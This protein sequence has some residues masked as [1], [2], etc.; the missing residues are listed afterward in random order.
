MTVFISRYLPLLSISALP[1]G[2][3]IWIS[4]ICADDWNHHPSY[5]YGWFILPL[6]F[7]FLYR[8][9]NFFETDALAP[10]S[11]SV[12]WLLPVPVV[13]LVL[14]LIRL[15][16]IFWRTIPWCIFT[17]G[18]TVTILILFRHG[19]RH[20]VNQLLF[21]VLFFGL[22]IP[23][24]TVI[25]VTVI[26]E[27]SFWVAQ[28]VGEFLM[29]SGVYCEVQGKIIT[30]TNGSVGVDEAC[31]GLRSLQAS[32]MVG[33]AVGEWRLMAWS[34]RFLL[35]ALAIGIA[36]LSN[37][38]RTY[39]LSLLIV[40]GGETL[41]NEWHDTI[42]TL[43]MI[44][45]TLA[46]V[47]VAFFFPEQTEPD[48]GFRWSALIQK[49]PVW[50]RGLA[51]TATSFF[52]FILAH[53]WFSIH[54]I[55][56]SPDE[57]FLNDS[58]WSESVIQQAPP[59]NILNILRADSGGYKLTQ[60]RTAGDLIA[61]HFFWKPSRSNGKVLFHR[62][63]VC[64]PG[65]GWTQEG[66]AKLIHG[67]LN[68]RKT[69]IHH[70]RFSRSSYQ[71]NLY[72]ICWTDD[73]PVAFEA[74]ENSYLQASFLTEFIQLGKRIFSVE[75]FGLATSTEPQSNQEWNALLSHLGALHFELTQ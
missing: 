14:E 72:W 16:P 9:L 74:S 67:T 33:F 29:L 64:M 41:F 39:V 36:F 19:G 65:G 46:I 61:Y 23:W 15:T 62:P 49:L 47:G 26:R 1:M 43:A 25:E 44:A 24:P 56:P 52:C 70:F 32:L 38:I 73:Q 51:L 37:L 18:A 48:Q 63:D 50:S 8:R 21:P 60:S 55:Q 71:T 35:V 22:A 5:S 7:Y 12:H 17:V 45:L 13:V 42:G 59:E 10:S 57:P 53:L 54:A 66:T 30:L 2:F 40:A 34:H 4:W 11:I 6:G 20:L 3:I 28:I 75:I 31:S 69:T 58:V 27:L 68:G